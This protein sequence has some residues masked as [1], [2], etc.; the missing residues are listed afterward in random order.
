ML[1]IRALSLLA[2]S[3]APPMP[4]WVPHPILAS[5]MPALDT[6]FGLEPA[7][8]LPNEIAGLAAALEAA[9]DTLSREVA[10]EDFAFLEAA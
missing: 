7:V 4:E 3:E 10:S 2:P 6:A 8:L 9:L 5:L 1:A